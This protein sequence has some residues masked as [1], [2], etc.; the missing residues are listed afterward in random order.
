MK[1]ESCVNVVGHLTIG[2]I[3]THHTGGS[4]AGSWTVFKLPARLSVG[5]GRI[6][7]G[8]GNP[9]GHAHNSALGIGA[10]WVRQGFKFFLPEK[11]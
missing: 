3:W 2:D 8:G 7:D 5:W 6:G 1:T 4:A 9:I 10:A 11:Y